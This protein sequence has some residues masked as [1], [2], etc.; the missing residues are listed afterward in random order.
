MSSLH[1]H[2]LW[3]MVLHFQMSLQHRPRLRHF[4]GKRWMS[5]HLRRF[6]L[7]KRVTSLNVSAYFESSLGRRLH[8]WNA[9][10]LLS[11]YVSASASALEKKRLIIENLFIGTGTA[12]YLNMR[13]KSLNCAQWNPISSSLLTW[14]WSSSLYQNL[15]PRIGIDVSGSRWIFLELLSTLYG[16]YLSAST[17]LKKWFPSL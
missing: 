1:L 13:L 11:S 10:K 17:S 4:S 12:T 2:C 8:H 6:V 3:Q 5:L 9:T 16:I 7:G 14:K 15:H